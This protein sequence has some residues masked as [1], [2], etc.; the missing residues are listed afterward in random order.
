VLLVIFWAA[1]ATALQITQEALDP[2]VSALFVRP[3]S[4]TEKALY[5]VSVIVV[6]LFGRHDLR[7][8]AVIMALPSGTGR[9]YGVDHHS[10]K[11]LGGQ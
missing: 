7:V 2:A 1:F 10:G 11:K 5:V 9:A 3:R 6:F 8:C 4:T